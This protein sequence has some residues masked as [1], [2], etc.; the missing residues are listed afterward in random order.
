[1]RRLTFW[2]FVVNG[3]CLAICTYGVFRIAHTIA[4]EQRDGPDFGDSLSFAFGVLP[5]AVTALAYDIGLGVWSAV[6]RTNPDSGRVAML[7][8]AGMATWSVAWFIFRSSG[9]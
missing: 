7:G 3:S 9:G 1:M 8:V 4:V 6:R 5:F 2:F